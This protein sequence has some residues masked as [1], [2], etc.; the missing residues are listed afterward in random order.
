MEGIPDDFLASLR[1]RPGRVVEWRERKVVNE[2]GVGKV[3]VGKVSSLG[4]D[5]DLDILV[6]K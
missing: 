1:K 6:V 3:W 4:V 2:A 5:V